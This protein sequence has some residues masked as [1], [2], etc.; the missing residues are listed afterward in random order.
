MPTKIHLVCDA[1]F[2]RRRKDKDGLLIFFDSISG[3]V[4]WFKFI[5]SETKEN[6]LEG[7]RYLEQREFE[8]LSV[9][10]DGRRGIPSIFRK[11]PV[12]VCQFHV[13]RR[14]L[15]RTTLNPKSEC[16]RRL[17]YIATH[18]IQERW[19][20]ERF[21]R[22]IQNLLEEFYQFLT[23][24]N[25]NNQYTHRNL[26]SAFYGIKLALPNL[27]TYQDFPHLNIPNTTN[28]VDGGVNTKLKEL[29]RHHR[30][31]R[32]DRRNKLL[33]NLLYNLKGIGRIHP[34]KNVL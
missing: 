30:G 2:F 19:T 29:N 3:K 8:I 13:Q 5:Q 16:G 26:R 9:T 20:R 17:K 11:Y 10:I 7:L 18:F 12:Q 4:L 14:I 33:V 22:E 27:F 21:T 1:T 23:E 28:H 32:A 31:M 15:N 24:K 34:L 25:D 6:Y